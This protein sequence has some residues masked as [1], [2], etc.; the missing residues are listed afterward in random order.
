MGFI[1]F[2]EEFMER[3]TLCWSIWSKSAQSL[4]KW[5]SI[6]FF[7]LNLDQSFSWKLDFWVEG[8]DRIL[9]TNENWGKWSDVVV[10]M[11]PHIISW[12]KKIGKYIDNESFWIANSSSWM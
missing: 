6:K 9:G 1:L 4:S 11:L 2:K 12:E 5:S 10:V 8:F 7:C 3:L